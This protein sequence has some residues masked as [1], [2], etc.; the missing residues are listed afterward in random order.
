MTN[1]TASASEFIKIFRARQF[2]RDL[3]VMMALNDQRKRENAERRAACQADAALCAELLAQAQRRGE[4]A[5]DWPEYF[6]NLDINY[7]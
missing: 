2:D 6:R 7:P 4:A 3:R 1:N 5:I